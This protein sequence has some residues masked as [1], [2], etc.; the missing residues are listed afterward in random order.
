MKLEKV[1]IGSLDEVDKDVVAQY[2]PKELSIDRTVPWTEH[3][4]VKAKKGSLEY[5]G[6]DGQTMSL[7]LFFDGYES[8][9][10]VQ[11]NVTKLTTLSKVRNA[12][13]PREEYQRPHLVDW[14]P[15][16]TRLAD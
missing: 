13:N 14:S 2:N 7:E 10:S 11:G 1:T 9:E 6:G 3:K 4:A 5:A 15:W 8:G 12:D 16:L